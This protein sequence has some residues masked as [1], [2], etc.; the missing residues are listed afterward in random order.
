[1]QDSLN[2]FM[3]LG[4]PAWREARQT[5][6]R[7]LSKDE[8]RLRDD[9]ALRQAAIIPQVCAH[10][11]TLRPWLEMCQLHPDVMQLNFYCASHVHASLQVFP[12]LTRASGLTGTYQG[13]S[14]EQK[15]VSAPCCSLMW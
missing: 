10:T 5:L 4:K 9:E 2:A 6:T 13:L 3:S 12:G 7:L 14:Q 1:M 15:R 11:N 8:G